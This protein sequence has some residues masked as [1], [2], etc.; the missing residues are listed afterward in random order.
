MN[1]RVQR[2]L[3]IAIVVPFA[4]ASFVVGSVLASKKTPKT[5]FVDLTI[6][7]T[8]T[9]PEFMQQGAHTGPFLVQGKTVPMG[10][11]D[12]LVDANGDPVDPDYY[13]GNW[14]C[15][16]WMINAEG[17]AGINDEYNLGA[18]GGKVFLQGNMSDA[19]RAIVGGTGAFKNARGEASIQ[20]LD[21]EP[22]VFIVR[23]DFETDQSGGFGF[24]Q[25]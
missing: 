9:N 25:E 4:V 16:G 13:A 6:K 17:S 7:V 21:G 5:H 2:L 20:Y 12:N 8:P 18:L 19:T 11:V 1:T 23:F 3:T 15:W 14:N 22:G 24:K 10:L